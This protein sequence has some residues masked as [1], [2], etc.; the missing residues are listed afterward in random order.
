MGF[1][2]SFWSPWSDPFPISSPFAPFPAWF[3]P[4]TIL[5]FL[6][7]SSALTKFR[8]GYP[9]TPWRSISFLKSARSP[10]SPKIKPKNKKTKSR[11][12]EAPTSLLHKQETT[13]RRKGEFCDRSEGETKQTVL[14]NE[15][16]KTKTQR[17]NERGKKHKRGKARTNRQKTMGK[18]MIK[19][20]K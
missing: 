16:Q 3:P 19:S 7:Y 18:T 5:I 15:S 6:C 14:K 2:L 12:F 8:N 9:N 13:P 20:K 17:R 1:F 10:Y 11:S 4:T